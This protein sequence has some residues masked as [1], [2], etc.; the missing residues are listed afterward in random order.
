MTFHSIKENI[1]RSER[2]IFYDIIARNK[3][4]AG[5]SGTKRQA[6]YN[7]QPSYSEAV[8]VSPQCGKRFFLSLS[9]RSVQQ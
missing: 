7:E 8:S 6:G 3:R 4:Q 1:I 9:K 2:N 5:M